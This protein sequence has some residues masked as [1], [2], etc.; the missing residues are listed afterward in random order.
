[1]SEL[2]TNVK[3]SVNVEGVVTKKFYS[4]ASIVV[5]S[6]LGGPLAGV[7]M[8]GKNH[9]SLGNKEVAQK[10]LKNGYILSFGMFMILGLLPRHIAELIPRQFLPLV[11]ILVLHQYFKSI[12]EG[13]VK[14]ALESG[15]KKESGWKV[16][17]VFLVALLVSAAVVLSFS[18][19]SSLIFV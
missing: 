4:L 3:S 8:L 18:I 9:E 12:Q 15:A 7:Y 16:L 5:G 14:K 6:V 2:Q 10:F 19:L 13:D 11:Y 1:M 17:G